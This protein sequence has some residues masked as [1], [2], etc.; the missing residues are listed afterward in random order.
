MEINVL[1]LRDHS[2]LVAILGIHDVKF[3]VHVH[4]LPSPAIELI[5]FQ[6]KGS[7]SS[8]GAMVT[9]RAH[10]VRH[11]SVCFSIILLPSSKFPL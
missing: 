7:P 8:P 11:V 1:S 5:F 9:P 4:T 10:S 2:E 3:N 6:A